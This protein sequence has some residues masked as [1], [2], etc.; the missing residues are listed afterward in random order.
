MKFGKLGV[1]TF[2]DIMNPTQLAELATRVEGLGYSTLW[3]PEAFN[4]ET[5]AIGGYLLGP[6]KKLIVALD[7]PVGRS[8]RRCRKAAR[9]GDSPAR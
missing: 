7:R 5:F 8:R 9:R 2:T 6:S 3:Y 4:Y 1:F